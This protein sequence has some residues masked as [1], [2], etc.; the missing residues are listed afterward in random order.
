M[1]IRDAFSEWNTLEAGDKTP[2]IDKVIKK[3]VKLQ[4]E[5]IEKEVEE[6][7]EEPVSTPIEAT[8]EAT[9]Q[10]LTT[11]QEKYSDDKLNWQDIGKGKTNPITGLSGTIAHR[12]RNPGALKLEFANAILGKTISSSK[13]RSRE[14]AINRAKELYDGVITLDR[15]GFIV[16]DSVES[17]RGAQVQLLMRAHKAR[18]IEQMLPKYAIPDGSGVTHHKEYAKAIYKHGDMHG[19]DL[20]DKKIGDMSKD[21]VKILTRAMARVEGGV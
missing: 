17:G 21:E 4:E 18:T 11:L 2:A 8:P 13:M 6:V 10:P 20:R 14:T 19:V 7:V 3:A 12:N 16:F 15:A 1:W 5:R 9:A